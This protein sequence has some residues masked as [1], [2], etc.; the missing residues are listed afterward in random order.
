MRFRTG[1]AELTGVVREF[2]WSAGGSVGM[3]VRMG[4]CSC[5]PASWVVIR[6]ACTMEAGCCSSTLPYS[7]AASSPKKGRL[8]FRSRDSRS[9]QKA[10]KQYLTVSLA[11]QNCKSNTC[12]RE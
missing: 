5:I 7:G 1:L 12:M 8:T 4:G 11:T 9:C 2:G 3:G 10:L 6:Y